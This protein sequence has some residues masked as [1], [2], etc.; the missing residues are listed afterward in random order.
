MNAFASQHMEYC[1][2]LDC[3]NEATDTVDLGCGEEGKIC[4]ECLLRVG[5]FEE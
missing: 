4:K 3:D 1:E 2:Q 5:G